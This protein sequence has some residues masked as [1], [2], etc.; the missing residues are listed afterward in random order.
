MS[1]SNIS[2]N[3]GK[4]FATKVDFNTPAA[5]RLRRIRGMKDSIAKWGI[6]LGGVSIIGA[7][8]LICFYL[9]F[10]VAPL[11]APSDI[12]KNSSYEA[13]FTASESVYM[14]IEEQSEIA[15]SISNRG[16]ALFFSTETGKEVNRVELPIPAGVEITSFAED[17]ASSGIVALGLSDGTAFLFKQKYNITF[18]SGT[19]RVIQPEILFNYGEEPVEIDAS[20]SALSQIAFRNEE[21]ELGFAAVTESNQLLYTSFTKAEDFMTEAITLEPEQVTIENPSGAQFKQ[22]FVAQGLQWMMALDDK[23]TMHSYRVFNL[24]NVRTIEPVRVTPENVE[25]TAANWLLGEISVLIGNSVG[26]ISQWFLVRD[27]NNDWT[28]EKVR[29]FPNMSNGDSAITKIEP[30]HRRKGF[31]AANADGEVGFF[32]STA[33][34]HLMTQKVSDTSIEGMSISPRA[35]NLMVVDANGQLTYWDVYNK[36]PEVS[37]EAL[38]QQVWYE[39]Y[40]KEEFIWQS[41]A[42]NDDFEPKYSIM[43]LAFGTLKA[44]F[45]AMLLA[46]PLA[47]AGAIYT[48]YF[49]GP[50]LRRKVKPIIELMEALPTVILG[51]LAGLALAPFLEENMPGVFLLLMVL[52]LAIVGFGFFWANLPSSIRYRVPEGW[53][54]ALL[55]PVVIITTLV[56]I[57]IGPGIEASLFGGSMPNWL[58]SEFGVDYSQRNALVVGFAM[59]FAVIPTIFSI[60]EDALFSV[61]KHL[62]FGSLALGATPWQT[63]TRVVLPTASPGIFS[64]LMIGMG[65]AVGE[66]MIVLMATG[67]TPIMDINIF[68]GMRTL[69]ANIAVEIPESEVGS[70]H[71][72]ILFLTGFVLFLFTFCVNTLAEVVRQ[73]LRRKYG[74]L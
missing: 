9:F 22:L 30:E 72:R 42:A 40:E 53:D 18:P 68:E 52:P 17:T 27:E 11:F 3:S 74:D 21:D 4:K 25:V 58:T 14:N 23:N 66:T 65:R 69:A 43:P 26:E 48:A 56:C 36:H 6:S 32:H 61:P 24:N 1:D 51:F 8:L 5:V 57:E 73:R 13:P 33:R 34:V 38:W 35:H 47:I 50:T 10:E 7:V 39:N 70:T 67:N 63:L 20:G 59:G 29:E 19:Q 44:A 45:Y 71:Y 41:S 28:F 16:E 37:F 60:A 12:E 54:S 31:V 15:L 55:V 49:M 62:T 46:A 2:E 64:A